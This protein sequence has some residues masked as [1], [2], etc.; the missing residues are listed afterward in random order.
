[1]PA[2][3]VQAASAVAMRRV[4]GVTLNIRNTSLVD[5]YFDRNPARLNRTLVG[6]VPEGTPLLAG[7]SMTWTLFPGVVWWRAISQVKIEVQD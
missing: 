3:T 1:M 6:A 2:F 7:E 4:K 5:V